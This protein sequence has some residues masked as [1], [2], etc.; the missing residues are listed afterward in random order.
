MST[1]NINLFEKTFFKEERHQLISIID[2]LIDRLSFEQEKWTICGLINYLN[3]LYATGYYTQEVSCYNVFDVRLSDRHDSKLFFIMKV[4]EDEKY[5]CLEGN[6]YFFT[7]Q[8]I[9][10]ISDVKIPLNT[11]ES[12]SI[13]NF[14][15]KLIED[16]RNDNFLIDIKENDRTY[17]KN[18]GSEKYEGGWKHII[19]DGCDNFPLELINIILN[20]RNTFLGRNLI[21]RAKEILK[22]KENI[23]LYECIKKIIRRAIDR[24]LSKVRKDITMIAPIYHFLENSNDAALNFILP[25]HIL[26]NERPDCVLVFYYSRKDN[27]YI[28]TT[29]LNMEEALQDARVLGSTKQ[30]SWL[31]E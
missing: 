27:S 18:N 5:E 25:L 23:D 14:Y 16:I 2:E 29:L 28:G 24:S 21:P 6:K 4:T 8:E 15:Y 12:N 30:Y 10:K 17:I 31:R 9:E 1:N 13:D 20:E 19:I 26:R 11:E 22:N 7:K 3:V